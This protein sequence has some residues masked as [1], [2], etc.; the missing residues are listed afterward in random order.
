[1]LTFPTPDSRYG[2]IGGG[3]DLIGAARRWMAVKIKRRRRRRWFA[4]PWVQS[5]KVAIA[6]NVAAFESATASALL[7]RKRCGFR[8]RKRPATAAGGAATGS[9]F[10]IKVPVAPPSE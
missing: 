10:R 5:T 9:I 7:Q 3:P 6:E 1:V 2:Q 8:R 4:A